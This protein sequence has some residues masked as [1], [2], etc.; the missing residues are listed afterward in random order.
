M[1]STPQTPIYAAGSAARSS[2]QIAGTVAG[3]L[4]VA[5]VTV[6]VV[7]AIFPSTRSQALAGAMTAV[8]LIGAPLWFW[9]EY[10]FIYRSTDGG[11]N[12]SFEYFKHG[13]QVAGAIWAGLAAALGAFTAS[14]YTKPVGSNYECKFE[15][16][17]AQWPVGTASAAVP[18]PIVLRDVQ[19]SCKAPAP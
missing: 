11:Q 16:P 14:D 7:M 10:F 5:F 1:S 13:Q 12:D 9:W 17:A 8:W 15:V 4:A 19:L 2:V 3:V 18:S 6:C